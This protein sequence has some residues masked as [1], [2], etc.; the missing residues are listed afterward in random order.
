VNKTAK[1]DRTGFVLVCVLWALAVLTILTF[2]FARR[3]LLDRRAAAVSGDYVQARFLARGAVEC[4]LAGIRNDQ[5]LRQLV[6]DVAPTVTNTPRTRLPMFRWT[7]SGNLIDEGEVFASSGGPDSVED[8]CVY[9]VQDAESRI[10]LNTAPA[11]IIEEIPGIGFRTVNAILRRRGNLEEGEPPDPFIAVEEVMYLAGVNEELWYGAENRP[12][13]RDLVTIWGDGRINV[14]TASADVLNC[15]PDIR[16]SVV[17]A[18]VSHRAGG[19]GELHTDDDRTF[20]SFVEIPR[21]LDVSP[22]DLAPVVEFCSLEPQF[23]RI[24]GCATRRRGKVRAECTAVVAVL[25]DTQIIM[26]WR[27]GSGAS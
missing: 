26:D 1:N 20:S 17:D 10:S 27:E 6:A 11:E 2:G 15:I 5:A 14:N 3:A 21:I 18:I 16:E 8:F 9:R 23:Y 24:T 13:L 7:T 22:E 12:G 25:E 4:G 19:D